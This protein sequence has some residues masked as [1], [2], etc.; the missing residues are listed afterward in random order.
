MWYCAFVVCSRLQ[1]IEP[2]VYY[3]PNKS[4]E[5]IGKLTKNRSII[6]LLIESE[7]W[8][9]EKKTTEHWH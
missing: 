1:T 5:T 7:R 6:E 8:R 9:E 2:Q 4:N 3:V